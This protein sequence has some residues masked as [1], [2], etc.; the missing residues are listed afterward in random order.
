MDRKP[1]RI[2]R[3][4]TKRSK[5]DCSFGKFSE[6]LS[7]DAWQFFHAAKKTELTTTF[8]TSQ[9]DR[10]ALLF[11][12][13]HSEFFVWNTGNLRRVDRSVFSLEDFAE[14]GLA[15]RFGEAVAYLTMVKWGYVYWDRIATLWERAVAKSGMTHPERVKRAKAIASKLGVA[16]PDWNP[17][18]LLKRLPGMFP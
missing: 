12:A 14:G 6:H 4:S 10:R 17:I 13:E 5:S 15:G 7:I 9:V 8:T 1:I 3:G 16:R 2:R 18:S 11:A